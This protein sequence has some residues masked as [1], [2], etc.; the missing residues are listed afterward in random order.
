MFI[1]AQG[2]LSTQNINS[3]SNFISLSLETA[4]VSGENILNYALFNFLRSA[5][6]TFNIYCKKANS[7]P[8]LI[9]F[10]LNF[11]EFDVGEK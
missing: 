4:V 9:Y 8:R 3:Q 1:S 11:S 7:V 2:N 6:L 5:E 10:L